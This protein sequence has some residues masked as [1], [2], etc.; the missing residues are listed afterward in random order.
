[1]PEGPEGLCNSVLWIGQHSLTS[2][3]IVNHSTTACTMDDLSPL[4]ECLE[5]QELE[6]HHLGLLSMDDQRVGKL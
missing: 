4:T 6:I 5:L 2:I 1:M 3:R